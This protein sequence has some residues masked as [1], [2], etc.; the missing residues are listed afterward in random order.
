MQEVLAISESAID[1]STIIAAREDSNAALALWEKVFPWCNRIVGRYMGLVY[2]DNA[3]SREDLLQEAFIAMHEAANAYDPEKSGFLTY[4]E[5]HVKRRCL[6]FL[7]MHGRIRSERY[8]T[9]SIDEPAAPGSD[10]TRADMIEDF[11]F[12]KPEEKT[13]LA[14]LCNDMREEIGLLPPMEKEFI[15]QCYLHGKEK[16]VFMREN[17]LTWHQ[18]YK[19]IAPRAFWLLSTSPRHLEDHLP[20]VYTNTGLLSWKFSGSSSVER[21]LLRKEVEEE[22]RKRKLQRQQGNNIQ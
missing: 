3:V 10:T 21:H 17:G 8:S 9:I 4:L 5:I 18:L 14:D 2:K 15:V 12:D 16:T 19:S 13:E 6:D 20:G 22:R 1:F 7:G 11:L